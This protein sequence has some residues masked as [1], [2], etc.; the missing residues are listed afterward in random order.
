MLNAMDDTPI[1]LSGASCRAA[2]EM[3]RL[4]QAELASLAGIS[5]STVRR[6]ENNQH[7]VSI[8]AI[9][10]IVGALKKEGALFVTGSRA[11]A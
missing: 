8:Y 5:V 4:S 11:A 9:K 1:A 2:R 7:K 10:Q 3:L 6:F